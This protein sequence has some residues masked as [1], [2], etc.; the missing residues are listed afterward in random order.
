MAK[1]PKEPTYGEWLSQALEEADLSVLGLADKTG[2]SAMGIYNIVNGVTES[3]Q[4]STREKIEKALKSK[5][6]KEIT[7][8]IESESNVVGMGS[9]EEFFPFDAA[10]APEVKGVYVFYDA[11]ERPVYVGKA[12]KQTIRTRIDQHREKFWFRDPIVTKA[13]YI[14]IK[15]SSLCA[16]VEMLLI[17]FLG[18][19]NLLNK[20]GAEAFRLSDVGEDT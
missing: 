18:S 10:E 11:F 7:D 14:E 16:K 8:V 9:L 19:H 6:Q 17:R 13:R 5:P 1:K 12:V 3:P 4:K 15:D 2:L 20:R